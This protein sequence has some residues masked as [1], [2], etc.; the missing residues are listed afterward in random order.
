[1]SGARFRIR[2]AYRKTGRLKYLSHLELI[3]AMERCVRRA[4]LPYAI[5]EGFS[6]HMKCAHSWALSVGVAS[7]CEYMDVWLTDYLTPAKLLQALQQASVDELAPYELNYI[8]DKED[9]ITKSHVQLSYLILY[10]ADVNLIESRLTTLLSKG[11]LIAPARNPKKKDKRI[12]L[13]EH[14]LSRPSIKKLEVAGGSYNIEMTMDTLVT[15]RGMLNPIL[16]AE[17]LTEGNDGIKITEITRIKQAKC[18]TMNNN[19]SK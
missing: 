16:F 5:S 7:F 19:Y 17:A 2:F 9:A 18:K 6:P 12:D 15:E 4:G 8:S 11:E 13:N 10:K 1:M 3:R 14:L